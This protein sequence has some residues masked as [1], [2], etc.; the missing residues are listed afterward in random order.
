MNAPIVTI[1]SKSAPYDV[2]TSILYS[3]SSLGGNLLPVNE[4]ENSSLVYFRVYNNFTGSATIATMNNVRLTLFDSAD[5]NSHTA[6]K[7]PVSQSWVRVYESGYGES[8]VS[9][10]AFT[11]YLGEDTPIGRSGVDSYYPE[12]GS[13]GTA[14]PYI[15][16]GV[17]GNGVGFI[18]F[19][20]Y[21]QAP[22][23]IGIGAYTFAVSIDYEWTS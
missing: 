4:G 14:T 6:M 18:E 12:Y 5:V 8:S 2:I 10:G 22:E 13:D 16:A 9:P 19:A 1:R 21:V 20:S 17:S 11:F 3:Q 15:R 7:S 23:G